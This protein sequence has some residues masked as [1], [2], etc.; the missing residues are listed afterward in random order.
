VTAFLIERGMEGF[1]SSPKVK[2]IAEPRH[3]TTAI[4]IERGKKVFNSPKMEI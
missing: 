2:K 3:G 4:V 1:S